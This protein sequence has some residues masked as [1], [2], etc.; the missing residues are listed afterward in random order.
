MHSDIRF[1]VNDGHVTVTESF[2]IEVIDV[3]P[4]DIFEAVTLDENGDGNVERVHVIFDEIVLPDSPFDPSSI[5]VE[6]SSPYSVEFVGNYDMNLYFD[7]PLTG[8]GVMELSYTAPQ[9]SR[10]FDTVG[11]YWQPFSDRAL[12]DGAT[13]VLLSALPYDD[14][15]NGFT[16]RIVFTFSETLPPSAATLDGWEIYDSTGTV[17]VVAHCT[18]VEVSGNSLILYVQGDNQR[19]DTPLLFR[20]DGNSLTDSGGN[21]PVLDNNTSPELPVLEVLEGQPPSVFELTC[22]P[23]DPD[24]EPETMN[25]SWEFVRGPVPV[26]I[27]NPTSYIAHAEL[28]RPGE[29]EMRVTVS[30]CFGD[31]VSR[32][33]FIT[34]RNVAPVARVIGS[35][36]M[37]IADEEGVIL[38]ASMSFDPNAD[39]CTFS[40]N[41]PHDVTLDYP[42]SPSPVA[43]FPRVGYFTATVTVTDPFG[44]SDTAFVEIIVF[45]ESFTPPTA[46]LGPDRQAVA[47]NSVTLDTMLNGTGTPPYS[48]NWKQTNG[49]S[50]QIDTSEDGQRASFTPTEP[51]LYTLEVEVM[52]A[53]CYY[54]GDSVNIVV[55][56]DSDNNPPLA[57]AGEN[58]IRVCAHAI[59]LDGTGS[60]DPDGD[61]SLFLAG[62]ARTGR[63]RKRL[64][65]HADLPSIRSRNLQDRPHR[66]RRHGPFGR[67]RHHAAPHR[68]NLRAP[69]CLRRFHPPRDQGF[70]TS[71]TVFRVRRVSR[72]AP[73]RRALPH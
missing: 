68:R 42:T 9:S 14:S 53:H 17:D 60:F 71:R 16:D 22:D 52:D 20:Y 35:I 32:P 72:T 47:G 31:S 61:P 24:Q 13:M 10:V 55:H 12:T 18:S 41:V 58:Q 36:H 4:P 3:L 30:D 44:L 48:V 2:S 1:S 19:P 39:P 29:Y 8:T 11:H 26:T 62:A 49:P 50:V 70:R 51:G 5:T 67:G 63:N 69:C 59:T 57:D 23:V 65:A 34:V 64:I 43:T 73:V 54:S 46:Q 66:L 25:Y 21:T 40:W 15:G 56:A 28:L 38:D 37:D 7:P 6:G 33:K 45:S 27:T